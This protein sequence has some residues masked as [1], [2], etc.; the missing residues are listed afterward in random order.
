M[1]WIKVARVRSRVGAFL[2]AG[3][4]EAKHPGCVIFQ[5]TL[6]A[7]H[8]VSIIFQ[9]TSGAEH[10][11]SALYFIFYTIMHLYSKNAK[12]VA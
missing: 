3:V 9:K 7:E 2:E 4:S 11:G 6:G 10:L 8:P 12:L 1:H 5:K